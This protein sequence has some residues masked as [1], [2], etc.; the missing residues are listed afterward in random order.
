MEVINN[1]CNSKLIIFL[2]VSV[3]LSYFFGT[4]V[5]IRLNYY[6]LMTSKVVA[7]TMY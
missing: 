2:T 7:K 1:D 6:A 3:I 5:I 4:N